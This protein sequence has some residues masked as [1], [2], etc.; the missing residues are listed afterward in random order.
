MGKY[1]SAG[2][3]RRRKAISVL[4]KKK[5]SKTKSCPEKAWRLRCNDS[6]AGSWKERRY[7]SQ[8]CTGRQRHNSEGFL[9]A[10]T[11]P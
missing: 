8:S 2:Q 3:E 9:G 5:Q 1:E 6:S 11:L 4:G 7:E 10:P